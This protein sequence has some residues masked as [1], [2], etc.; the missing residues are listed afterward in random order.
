MKNVKFNAT[1]QVV[2]DTTKVTPISG[3][4]MLD[5][6]SIN[7]PDT[8]DSDITRSNVKF[9][10]KSWEQDP[11]IGSLTVEL[12]ADTLNVDAIATKTKL[13]MNKAAIKM[14]LEPDS[15]GNR[16][17]SLYGYVGFLDL[18]VRSE[19]FPLDV[20]M[21]RS[22]LTLRE[23]RFELYRSRLE[24]GESDFTATGWVHQLFPRLFNINDDITT[25]ELSLSSDFIN[26]NELI[27]AS[28]VTTTVLENQE[29]TPEEVASAV[30]TDSIQNVEVIKLPRKVKADFDM[31]IDR[32]KILD[33]EIENIRGGA[34]L[35]RGVLALDSLNMQ[36][37][38]SQMMLSALYEPKSDSVAHSL[39]DL[40]AEHIVL[41]M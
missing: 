17:R 2:K 1:S 26:M 31:N 6:F 10:I 15:L 28:A 23:S 11:S 34:R 40:R 39:I 22:L 24:V 4:L 19:L 18:L 8:L 37:S 35:R 41:R 27:N 14:T 32:M 25:A 20:K 36:M 16:R 29:S 7:L 9:S 13:G 21:K 3:E 30:I 33:N 5:Q 38:G 12:T